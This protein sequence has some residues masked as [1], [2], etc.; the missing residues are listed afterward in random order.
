MLPLNI[1]AAVDVVN[2][3]EK[4]ADDLKS[5][6]AA[7]KRSYPKAAMKQFK[8]DMSKYITNHVNTKLGSQFNIVIS[9]IRWNSKNKNRQP[10]RIGGF[11]IYY[12]GS[13]Y[14]L[15]RSYK[16]T[17][18]EFYTSNGG[19]TDPILGGVSAVD[20]A[21]CLKDLAKTDKFSSPKYA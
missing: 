19:T 16:A 13:I 4:E 10:F 8:E 5:K 3:H 2:T 21:K 12:K 15:Y 1:S 9:W 6:L 17:D 14:N 20:V 7:L 11:D 18:V